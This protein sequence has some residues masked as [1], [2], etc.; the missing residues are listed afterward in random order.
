M[1]PEKI[2][3]TL[4]VA[5]SLIVLISIGFGYGFAKLS[6][7][8]EVDI[9]VST[10]I[11]NTIKNSIQTGLGQSDYPTEKFSIEE[12][13]SADR[14]SEFE[15][16]CVVSDIKIRPYDGSKII[17][18]F[19]GD[20]PKEKKFRPFFEKQIDKGKVTTSI[21]ESEDDNF[22]ES[23]DGKN[24]KIAISFP[25]DVSAN[26]QLQSIAGD[27]N[28]SHLKMRK[29]D[30]NSVSGSVQVQKGE[31]ESITMR[32]ISGD[33]HLGSSKVKSDTRMSSTS[34]DIYFEGNHQKNDLNLKSISGDIRILLPNETL[35]S[36]DSKTISGDINSEFNL[37]GIIEKS[38]TALKNRN[39][40]ASTTI[41]LETISGDITLQKNKQN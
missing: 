20:V 29:M 10:S 21:K 9:N 41:G 30:L 32:T 40:K 37:E 17:I 18:Q 36:L 3:K 38:E 6:Q 4:I 13:I 19:S 27:I 34:G 33:M 1:K 26:L 14:I 28:A 39:L 11:K 7:K 16:K 31:M 2:F 22:S 8:G 35:L 23:K 24:F 25:K 5:T 12:E 15:F